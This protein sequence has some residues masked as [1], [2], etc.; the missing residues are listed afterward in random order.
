VDSVILFFVSRCRIICCCVAGQEKNTGAFND[1][2]Q[3]LAEYF[4]VNNKIVNYF[5]LEVEKA[6]FCLK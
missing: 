4:Q 3:L 2:S 1:I 6:I 5:I